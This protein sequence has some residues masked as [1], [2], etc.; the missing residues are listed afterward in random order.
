MYQLPKDNF[1]WH[2]GNGRE[3]A[4]QTGFADLDLQ[5]SESTF[6]CHLTARFHASSDLGPTEIRQLES[7]LRTRLDFIYAV[8]QEMNYLDQM[9]SLDWATLDCKHP[10]ATPFS[11]EKKAERENAAREKMLREL[12][13][14]RAKRRDAD[15]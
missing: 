6:Q 4:K 11:E 10:E 7:D 8:S 12:E 15:N 5:G 14:R 3:E 2:W 13:R 1:I 9:R